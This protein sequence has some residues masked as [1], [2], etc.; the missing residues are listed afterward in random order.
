MPDISGFQGKYAVALDGGNPFTCIVCGGEWF[1]KRPIML[2]TG[3]MTFMG[4]D[5]ANLT[6][7]GL[8]CRKCGHITEFAD[9]MVTLSE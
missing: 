1:S 3:G 7:L 2:N 8:A 5:W 9:G 6:S 4:F